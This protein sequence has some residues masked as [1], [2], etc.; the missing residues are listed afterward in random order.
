VNFRHLAPLALVALLACE[1]PSP[2]TIVPKEA[3][4]A[5]VSPAGI[6]ILLKVEATNPNKYALSAQS[7]TGK[8]KLD[9]KWDLGTVT[10]N[11]PIALP[12]ATP[13]MID[14][15]MTLPWTDVRALGA[16]AAAKR[17]VPYS[18]EGTVTIGGDKL[19]VALPFA[20]TGTIAH[21][22]IAAAAMKGI[23]TLPGINLAP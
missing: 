21:E 16:L 12:P 1:K 8:A 7:V 6:D 18:V 10:I 20:M 5:A 23:P 9:G 4:V 14:V 11:K 13:T 17:P 15:P 19:N 2:P 22:Q 3:R